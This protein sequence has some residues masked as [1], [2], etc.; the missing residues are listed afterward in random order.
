MSVNVFGDASEFY[1]LRVVKVDDADA[2]DLQWRDDIL[3][4]EPPVQ[5]VE[6]Y[7]VYRVEVMSVIDDEV[8]ASLGEYETE[9]EAR[10]VLA[11]TQDRLD[12]MTKA[13]FDAQYVEPRD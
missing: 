5:A 6:E 7:A 3:Y 2:P 12:D 13:Q 9:D 11:E 4:R 10:D 8:V 1:R